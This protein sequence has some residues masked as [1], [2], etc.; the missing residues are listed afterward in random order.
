[1]K[2]SLKVV[3]LGMALLCTALACSKSPNQKVPIAP[4]AAHESTSEETGGMNGGGGG[5]CEREFKVVR[6]DLSSWIKLGGAA[7]LNLPAGISTDQ[8]TQAMLVEIEKARISCVAKGD[9]GHPVLVGSTPKTCRWD[10]SNSESRITCDVEK[11]NA[12]NLE[13]RYTLVHHEYASLAE[14]EVPSGDD[15]NYQISNQ[16]SGFLTQELVK[17][18]AVKKPVQDGE[19]YI[20]YQ[21]GHNGD[22]N[23]TIYIKGPKFLGWEVVRSWA[24]YTWL[25]FSG[26]PF[27]QANTRVCFAQSSANGLDSHQSYMGIAFTDEDIK[28]A[29]SAIVVDDNQSEP[30]DIVCMSQLKFAAKYP[31]DIEEFFKLIDP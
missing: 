27:G 26:A 21:R 2:K 14:L 16:I 5:E 31:R 1:M 17:K 10:K 6:D 4:T 7:E 19:A 3:S 11:L 29:L 24:G 15:S 22:L 12:T 28:K 9:D 8:Y 13:D 18:L 30:T 25:N 23:K 20:V